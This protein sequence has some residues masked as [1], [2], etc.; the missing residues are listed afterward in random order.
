MRKF[1]KAIQKF[2]FAIKAFVLKYAEPAVR[3]GYVIRKALESDQADVIVMLTKSKLDNEILKALRIVFA[4]LF[5]TVIINEQ[6]EKGKGKKTPSLDIIYLSA[7]IEE[8]KKLSPDLQKA[9][10]LKIVSK[11]IQ[12]FAE[13]DNIKLSTSEADTVAQTAFIKYK[14]A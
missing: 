2:L 12:V 4:V 13:K 1:I 11:L 10:L 9:A 3:V 6:P 14:L 7:V 8:I 5:P